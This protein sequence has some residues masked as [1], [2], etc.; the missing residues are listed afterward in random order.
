MMLA[1]VASVCLSQAGALPEPGGL[2]KELLSARWLSPQQ[3]SAAAR[4][5][6]VWTEADLRDQ[7]AH[8]QVAHWEWNPTSDH[9]T[10]GPSESLQTIRAMLRRGDITGAVVALKQFPSGPQRDAMLG[11][12]L[13]QI[14]RPTPAQTA[15]QTAASCEPT[16]VAQ[17]R[18]VL[19]AQI[20]LR[21]MNPDGSAASAQA[22]LTALGDARIDFDPTY[23]PL[24]LDEAALLNTWGHHDEASR[25]LQEAISLNPR[26]AKAWFELGKGHVRVFNFDGLER[27]V[28]ALRSIRPD[29]ELASLL[30]AEAALV[31][32]D[33]DRATDILNSLNWVPPRGEAL[34]IATAALKGRRSE[35]S[36][37]AQRL[38]R[39]RPGDVEP[40]A[41]TGRLLSL[42]R[43]HD[44]AEQWL[45]RALDVAP[46]D[47]RLWSQLGLMRVQAARDEAAIEAL[48]RATALDPF[49]RRAANSLTLMRRITG[50]QEARRGDI[51][52]RWAPGVDALFARAI[53]DQ[54]AH[55]H[56]AVEAA[57]SWTPSRETIVELHPDH[58]H[59]AV[60]VTGLPQVHTIAA[61]TGPLVAMEVPRRGAPGLHHGAWD[62]RAVLTHELAHVAHLDQSRARVPLW[63]TEGAAVAGEPVP[64]DFDART[65][66]ARRWHEGTLLAP[67]DLTWAFVRP[68]RSD[69]R[70]L[71]YAQSGWFV[72]YLTERFGPGLIG[73][74]MTQLGR[75]DTVQKAF[76]DCTGVDLPMLW[77]DF[78]DQHAPR[79]LQQW[80]LDLALPAEAAGAS[81][82][83][84]AALAEQFPANTA[85][86][87]LMVQ[88]AIEDGEGVQ[89][90]LQTLMALANARPL[91][92]WPCQTLA[93]WYERQGDPIQAAR[94]LDLVMRTRAGDP[95][96]HDRMAMLHRAAGDSAASLAAMA[97]AIE[98]DPWDAARRERAAALAIESGQVELARSHIDALILLEPDEPLHV[99]RREALPQLQ[100]GP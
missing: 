1:A 36:A 38:Q 74:L 66:L 9:L 6:G 71:A 59:F 89:Q 75:G 5:H 30:E 47:H 20:M 87:R 27:C 8:A 90:H 40:F 44:E 98:C 34:Q 60:R 62:W 54:V 79:T 33:W 48:E 31:Q 14:D 68:K 13:L 51:L 67:E 3:R 72:G 2:V 69:D 4:F 70:A 73:N 25:A 64:L 96:L 24:L 85:I 49:N 97:R 99:R 83:A 77:T 19:A 43:R 95:D 88:R 28:A 82:E 41:L 42:H 94:W 58:E 65:L 93:D 80:G 57:N 46:D 61:C 86:Q 29:H 39:R 21:Q 37:L 18:A 10:A 100:D 92:P 76:V 84:L 11:E 35:A 53:A 63:L 50:W 15:L 12:A 91:D 32:Q 23:W 17:A 7:P 45:R 81:R 26:A 55:V 16:T 52:L 56:D 78:I 22:L